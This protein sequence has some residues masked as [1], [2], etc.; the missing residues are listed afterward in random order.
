MC[1]SAPPTVHLKLKQGCESLIPNKT[2]KGKIVQMAWE[3][4]GMDAVEELEGEGEWVGAVGGWS[5]GWEG[6]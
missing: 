5:G 3:R 6:A 1:T 4:S 2:G